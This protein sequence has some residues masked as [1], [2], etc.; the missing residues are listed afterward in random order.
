MVMVRMGFCSRWVELIMRCVESV[1]FSVL[2]NGVPGPFFKSRR[3]LRQGDPLSSY[4]FLL[5]SEGFFALLSREEE[6]N[7][8]NG[9]RVPFFFCI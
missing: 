5:C 2:I 7:N 8:F 4:F 9:F 3:G 6:R 1:N